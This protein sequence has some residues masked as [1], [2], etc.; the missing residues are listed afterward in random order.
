MVLVPCNVVVPVTTKFPVV[1]KFKVV[2]AVVLPAV[3]EEIV[4][5][6]IREMV[7]EAPDITRVVEVAEIVP[8]A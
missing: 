4:V 3:N 5:V 6:E 8:V 2:L 7:E 1:P